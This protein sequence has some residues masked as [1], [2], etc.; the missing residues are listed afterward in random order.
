MGGMPAGIGA[1]MGGM[2]GGMGGLGGSGGTGGMMGQHS[3]QQ[4]Q[5]GGGIGHA[6]HGQQF[7]G[8]GHWGG[9]GGVMHQQG[10]YVSTQAPMPQ[11]N[12]RAGMN[13]GING[14]MNGGMHGRFLTQP[15]NP[16]TP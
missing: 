4:P 14:G 2:R 16:K 8:A 9:D 12:M 15:L 6:Q 3:A 5:Y 7:T 1:G 11:Q 10:G 13:G